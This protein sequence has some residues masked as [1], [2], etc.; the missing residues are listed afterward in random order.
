VSFSFS[1][2]VCGW[3]ACGHTWLCVHAVYFCRLITNQQYKGIRKI[4]FAYCDGLTPSPLC[5]NFTVLQEIGVLNLCLG[6]LNVIPYIVPVSRR[7]IS[8]Q[9]IF[10]KT[11][12]YI[13]V[14][15]VDSPTIRMRNGWLS[16][17]VAMVSSTC[18][19]SMSWS[20][21]WSQFTVPL[22]S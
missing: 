21:Q 7:I 12:I 22:S 2:C 5:T 8:K 13:F 20:Q 15:V 1:F 10:S 14:V 4:T 6:S 3:L 16:G 17:D 9:L 18:I 11:Y 19:I